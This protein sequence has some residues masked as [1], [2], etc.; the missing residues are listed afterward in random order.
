[1]KIHERAKRCSRRA[2]PGEEMSNQLEQHVTQAMG[3]M[4]V[5]KFLGHPLA[6]KG[7]C[8]AGCAWLASMGIHVVMHGS[9]G[10]HHPCLQAGDLLVFC[11]REGE[12][13]RI[14][15]A[16]ALLPNGSTERLRADGG[17]LGAAMAAWITARTG[18]EQ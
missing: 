5:L 6:E 16:A 9:S 15:A 18:G 14:C 2:R 4:A 7:Q 10:A 13:I 8:E 11:K 12:A 1:M 17:S 3:E